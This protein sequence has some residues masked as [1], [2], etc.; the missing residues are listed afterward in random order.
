MVKKVGILLF[1]KSDNEISDRAKRFEEEA[2]KNSLEPQIFY[3]ELFS[4]FF[5][6]ND[7]EIFYENKK[8]NPKDY[9]FFIG[10][11]T[12]HGPGNFD[13]FSLPRFL[14]LY[15]I[16]I[17]N[18]PDPAF[19]AKNKRESLIKLA[20]AKLPIVPTGINYSCFYLDEH[21]NRINNNKIIA[22]AN[23][24]SLG[25][26][27]SIFDSHISFISFMEFISSAKIPPSIILIQPFL[28]A[29]S[30]DL[31][32]FVVGDKVVATMKRK[33]NGIDF[34]ANLSK[35]GFG[36][37]IK[38]SQKIKNLS[39]KAAKILGLDYAGVDILF[40]HNKPYLLEV[41]PNPGFKIEE[42][43]QI[44]IAGEIIKYCAKKAK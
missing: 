35:G 28:D 9:R 42:I 12:T 30:E 17:F 27:V 40:H 23:S 7:L 41:N 3:N 39:I 10:V 20:L 18:S 34:R 36:E 6:E 24:S 44:N 11:Y 29:N 32:I 25:Y 4:V 16:K 37:P 8:L 13:H 1:S 5:K 38:I 33:A 31:R 26:G 14:E 22:K 15:G 43:T 2:L 21:L 19:L